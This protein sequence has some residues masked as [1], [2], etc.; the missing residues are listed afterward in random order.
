MQNF[1]YINNRDAIVSKLSNKVQFKYDTFG[2]GKHLNVMIG[3][4]K[5]KEHLKVYKENFFY[6]IP[7]AKL[8]EIR[9]SVEYIAFYQSKESFKEESG[10]KYYG[11]IKECIEYKR[12]ECT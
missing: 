6:H 9:E 1:Y 10:V 8:S 4:V 11:K 5:N 12:S 2:K 7:A 3:N